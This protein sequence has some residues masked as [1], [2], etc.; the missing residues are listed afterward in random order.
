[1]SEKAKEKFV[2]DWKVVGGRCTK[3]DGKNGLIWNKDNSSNIYCDCKA[4]IRKY[5]KDNSC[6][7]KKYN[8]YEPKRNY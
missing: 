6:Y 4:S 7:L 2:S 1:M 8:K 5:N 3:C